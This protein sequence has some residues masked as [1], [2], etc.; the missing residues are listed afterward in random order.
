MDSLAL[1]FR[2]FSG[3]VKDNLQTVTWW[4]FV[5]RGMEI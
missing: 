1:L 2:E 3:A 5:G 4:E